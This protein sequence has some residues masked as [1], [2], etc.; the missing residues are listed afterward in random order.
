MGVCGAVEFAFSS[1][2]TDRATAVHYAQGKASTVLELEMG[3]VDRGADVRCGCTYLVA[4]PVS[5]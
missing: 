4:Q 1:T 5:S 3:M 2:T